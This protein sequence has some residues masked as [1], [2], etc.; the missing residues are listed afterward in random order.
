M[1]GEDDYWMT[2][3]SWNFGGSSS[4]GNGG[5]S[6]AGDWIAP[7]PYHQALSSP[8]MN[9]GFNDPMI[10]IGDSRLPLHSQAMSADGGGDMSICRGERRRGRQAGRLP[11]AEKPSD[12]RFHWRKYGQKSVKGCE[13]PR[14]YYKC[15]FPECPVK[16]LVERDRHGFITATRYNG[17]HGHPETAPAPPTPT[18]PPPS[19]P[20]SMTMTRGRRW[21]SSGISPRT[22]M[23]RLPFPF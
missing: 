20:I 7:F 4:A 14:S 13:Y 21:S 6:A 22:T 12:D 2:T 19:P 17:K 9:G 8:A 18:P 5:G 1:A 15:T 11:P 10:T 16:K 23:T 3:S